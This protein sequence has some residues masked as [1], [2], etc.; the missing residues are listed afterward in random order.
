MVQRH[1]RGI[2][3]LPLDYVPVIQ[4]LLPTDD[5]DDYAF[6][7]S[8]TEFFIKLQWQPQIKERPEYDLIQFTRE[9]H[10]TV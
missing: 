7:M 2:S 1:R 6:Q 8:F 4:L 3:A 9:L 5:D 10:C